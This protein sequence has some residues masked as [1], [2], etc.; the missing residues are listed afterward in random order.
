VFNQAPLGGD[1]ELLGR[2]KEQRAIDK[3]K[4]MPRTLI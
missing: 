2:V 1:R 4:P 3:L